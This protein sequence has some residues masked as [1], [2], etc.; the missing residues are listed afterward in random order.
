M[1]KRIFGGMSPF[2]KARTP[3]IT[4]AIPALASTWPIY[5]D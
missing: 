4:P 3:L 5:M 1:L 2:S